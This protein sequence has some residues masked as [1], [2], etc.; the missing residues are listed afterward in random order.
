M[1]MVFGLD[2]DTYDGRRHFSAYFHFT[3]WSQISIGA[4]I[5]VSMPNVEIHLPFGFLRVGWVFNPS[6]DEI[7][8]S[9]TGAE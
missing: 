1:M 3:G 4:H 6:L 5:D 9:G 2:N 7:P 8:R